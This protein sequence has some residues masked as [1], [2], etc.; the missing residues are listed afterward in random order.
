L[1]Y[2]HGWEQKAIAELFK[3]DVRT[4]RR[5]WQA[6]LLNLRNVLKDVSEEGS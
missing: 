4:I 2:Y 6:A 3:V 1:I 5:R